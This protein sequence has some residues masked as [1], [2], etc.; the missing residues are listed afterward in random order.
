MYQLDAVGRLV[1]TSH[2]LS[3]TAAQHHAVLAALAEGRG[4]AVKQRHR[5]HRWPRRLWWPILEG[6]AS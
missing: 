1:P 4:T 5:R 6:R 2:Q 3:V